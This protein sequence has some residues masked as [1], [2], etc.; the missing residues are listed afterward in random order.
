MSPV[1]DRSSQIGSSAWDVC[2]TIDTIPAAISARPYATALPAAR[3]TRTIT[4]N[5]FMFQPVANISGT[6]SYFAALFVS[7]PSLCKYPTKT[8]VV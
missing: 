6:I 5:A 8:V 2:A 4:T 3:R 7:R 1:P